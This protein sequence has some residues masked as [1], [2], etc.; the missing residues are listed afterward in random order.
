MKPLPGQLELRITDADGMCLLLSYLDDGFAST[1]PC[2]A[3]G[4]YK[5]ANFIVAEI[6]EHVAPRR[7][8]SDH[9]PRA[10]LDLV[11]ST[12]TTLRGLLG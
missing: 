3:P 9:A 6:R 1:V 10:W 11:R 4:C 5:A 12:T 8:C 2:T 7:A